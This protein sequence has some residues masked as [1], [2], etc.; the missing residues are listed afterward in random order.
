MA[1]PA[2]AKTSGT[3]RATSEESS[4]RRKRRLWPYRAGSRRRRISP[5]VA[6]SDQPTHQPVVQMEGVS[7]G[8][9]E[10][11]GATPTETQAE[12]VPE[13]AASSPVCQANARRETL[14]LSGK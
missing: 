8:H 4:G 13:T 1:R 3:R 11:T 10:R 2:R 14:T 7:D 12:S 9:P 6:G 5:D